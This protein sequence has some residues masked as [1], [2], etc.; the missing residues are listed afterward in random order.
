M[1]IIYVQN[2]SML[3]L[4]NQTLTMWICV[5]LDP[6]IWSI[7]R[8]IQWSS[9]ARIIWHLY[10]YGILIR[11]YVS[12]LSFSASDSVCTFSFCFYECMLLEVNGGLTYLCHSTLLPL[13][14]TL[15][16]TLSLLVLYF[17]CHMGSPLLQ[18]WAHDEL[19]FYLYFQ[20]A[21]SGDGTIGLFDIR[22][23]SAISHLSVGSSCE[24]LLHRSWNWELYSLNW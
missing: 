12:Y 3:K 24:V 18:P 8:L 4:L 22:T 1:M 17:F 16:A 11:Q 2:P 10:N 19:H 7:P 23:C 5:S 21:G 9:I 6:R 20:Y 13:K 15:L 14:S